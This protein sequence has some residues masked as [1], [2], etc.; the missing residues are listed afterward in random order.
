[1]FKKI[2]AGAL[3]LCMLIGLPISVQAVGTADPQN[4]ELL[5]VMVPTAGNVSDSAGQKAVMYFNGQSNHSNATIG[6]DYIFTVGVTK[7]DGSTEWVAT[8]INADSY[9][10]SGALSDEMKRVKCLAVKLRNTATTFASYVAEGA[11]GFTLR[12]EEKNSNGNGYMDAWTTG[13]DWAVDNRLKAT[14]TE[15]GVDV[16]V[17]EIVM[18]GTS[19][20]DLRVEKVIKVNDNKLMV[21]FTEAVT[22]GTL[23]AN[24]GAL[25]LWVR[26]CNPDGSYSSLGQRQV[27]AVTVREG[28]E[29]VEMTANVK[30]V[31]DILNRQATPS[32]YKIMLHIADKA[33][34]LDPSRG[35]AGR[36][37]MIDALWSTADHQPLVGEARANADYVNVPVMLDIPVQMTSATVFNG[38]RVVL[39]FSESVQKPS[40][41]TVALNFFKDGQAH[42]D[43]VWYADKQSCSYY[44]G[45]GNALVFDILSATKS[46]VDVAEELGSSY[47]LQAS[48]ISGTKDDDAMV[49]EIRSKDKADAML[50]ATT[51]TEQDVARVSAELS[52]EK[53]LELLKAELYA[54]TKV[55]LTFNQDI[56]TVSNLSNHQFVGLTLS[57]NNGNYYYSKN[58]DGSYTAVPQAQKTDG[59]QLAQWTLTWDGVYEKQGNKIILTVKDSQR[60][61]TGWTLARILSIC[62]NSGGSLY[63]RI[64]ENAD[65][66]P[67]SGTVDTIQA[68]S[69]VNNALLAT[70]IGNQ[71]QV[72]YKVK[73]CRN[74]IIVERAEL[75]ESDLVAVTFNKAVTNAWYSQTDRGS[76]TLRLAKQDNK[77]QWVW[78]SIYDG[79]SVSPVQWAG[80]KVYNYD[81]RNTAPEDI[82]ADTAAS[83]VWYYQRSGAVDILDVLSTVNDPESS[84]YGLTLTLALER[85]GAVTVPNSVQNFTTADGAYVLIQNN[86]G[87]PCHYVPVTTSMALRN[88]LKIQEISIVDERN[89]I[90]S[91][92]ED[93]AS[94]RDVKTEICM[95]DSAG[96]AKVAIEVTPVAVDASTY[97]ITLPIAGTYRNFSALWR[98]AQANNYRLD[99][100]L[101]QTTGDRRDAVVDGVIGVSGM[102]LVSSF[103]DSSTRDAY[104]KTIVRDMFAFDPAALSIEKVTQIGAHTLVVEFNDDIE[105]V[106]MDQNPFIAL[107]MVD[108]KNGAVISV[109]LADGKVKYQQW[110]SKSVDY[111]EGRK[112]ALL[113]TFADSVDISVLVSKVNMAEEFIDY[114]VMLVME[115][116][117]TATADGS[118]RADHLV[119]HIRRLGENK[120]LESTFKVTSKT[121]CDGVLAPIDYIDPQAD[122]MVDKVEVIDQTRIVVTFTEAVTLKNPEATIRLVNRSFATKADGDGNVMAWSGKVSYYND[123][124]TQ[125]VFVLNDYKANHAQIPVTGLD[126][127]FSRGY[128]DNTWKLMLA[129]GDA[130]SSQTLNGL[131]DSI[132]S[133]TGKYVLADPMTGD[134]DRIYMDIDS[135]Q[136]AKG[137][138]TMTDVTVVSDTQ[139]IITFSGA[140]DIADKPYLAIRLFTEDG[141]MLWRTAD[142]TYG[143]ASKNAEGESNTPM[144]WSSSNWE[145]VDDSKTSIRVNFKTGPDNL[146]N[147]TDILAVDW[148]ALVKGSRLMIGFEEANGAVVQNNGRVDNISLVS[149]SRVRLTANK[150]DSALDGMYLP[151][152]VAYNAKKIT[153]DAKIIND[154]QIRISFSQ[155]VAITGTPYIAIRLVDEEGKLLYFEDGEWVR[156]PVQFGGTWKWENDS[157]TSLIW[158]MNGNSNFGCYNI[159]DVINYNNTLSM[160]KGASIRMVIEEAN[161]ANVITVGKQNNLVENVASTD[162]TNHLSANL[163]GTSDGLYMPLNESLLKNAKPI[164]LLSV[165]AVNNKTIEM[166]FSEPVTIMEGDKAPTIMLRYLDA[167]G[168][169]EVLANGKTANFKGDI[170]YK[171]DDPNV[172]VWT[173]N[174]KLAKNLSEI[175]Q[176]SGTLKWNSGARL[177]LVIEN[178]SE[179]IPTNTMRMW[180]ITSRDGVRTMSADIATN[181]SFILD[182]EVGYE[183]PEVETQA[184]EPEMVYEYYSDYTVLI[185][186]AAAAVVIFVA[187]GWIIRRRKEKKQ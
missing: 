58:P 164:T 116:S 146:S 83:E 120:Q 108:P 159:T 155:K 172:V 49:N 178:T 106:D 163:P 38:E 166:T 137:E 32:N 30:A 141:L 93:I 47:S 20:P 52:V 118:H 86:S 59:M 46:I 25:D 151:F 91:F 154:M 123:L 26:I 57:D 98:E 17:K 186:V 5:T 147:F 117:S 14:A 160:Y 119:H 29:W 138:L 6:N 40:D 101:T 132:V 153:A 126:E 122:V 22:V 18:D 121:S 24:G 73:D 27:T 104:R 161:Q 149:D 80:G 92:N 165:K 134:V 76:W 110:K 139:A 135:D 180:G 19:N 113:V 175:F 65:H 21:K 187:L 97:K 89:M 140:V 53:L 63:F 156:I 34:K 48:I 33:D 3:C 12:I 88:V 182:V 56:Q 130:T 28:G 60:G 2:I 174:T 1:M 68:A 128:E 54:Q 39:F 111:V 77:E 142:G 67:K 169:S 11:T 37:A 162:G 100:S 78:Q 124:Q 184:D 74:E 51:I 23:A 127:L 42:P 170:S 61:E 66:G 90:L 81:P 62:E 107:R 158:T 82:P 152:T 157:H 4:F 85:N 173:L 75:I 64:Q 8:S 148:D 44:G 84:Y 70:D 144:Q 45:Q 43:Y 129:L 50:L 95:R 109:P 131:I 99:L 136:I 13:S 167:A 176:Y 10:T 103:S 171:E 150:L 7:R 94:L 143:T 79:T 181:P 168:N 15:A 36:N 125:I 145:Y 112:D 105:L 69:N 87:N 16:I 41:L 72:R 177:A 114:P 102:N 133:T 183:L 115:E 96:K 9:Y 179:D 55:L 35:E 185:I 31:E 71:D